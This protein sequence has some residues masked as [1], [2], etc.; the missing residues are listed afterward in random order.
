MSSGRRCRNNDSPETCPH[1][2][3][4]LAMPVSAVFVGDSSVFEVPQPQNSK[5][6]VAIP[7]DIRR[8]RLPPRAP[9][10]RYTNTVSTASL[11]VDSNRF[12]LIVE[13]YDDEGKIRFPA[14]SATYSRH[15]RESVKFG[16]EN[17]AWLRCRP[18]RATANLRPL[19]RHTPFSFASL[20]PLPGRVDYTSKSGRGPSVN[21]G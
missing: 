7:V 6:R 5:D 8:V 13:I 14:K 11:A 9:H 2:T 19:P 17:G 18:W 20:L 12:A 3:A 4:K 16:G 21:T 15:S 1:E 10:V